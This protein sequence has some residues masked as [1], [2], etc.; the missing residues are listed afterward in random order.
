MKELGRHEGPAMQRSCS[1]HPRPRFLQPQA[2]VQ[3]G[4][5]ERGCP[6]ANGLRDREWESR[7]LSN[8][9]LSISL[10]NTPDDN[11]IGKSLGVT[12]LNP[13]NKRSGM[14]TGENIRSPRE[15]GNEN[16]QRCWKR[17]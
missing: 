3:G 10:Y 15:V 5:M 8:A 12:D 1:T 16:R 6:P 2:S 7:G 14:K 4:E 13:A 9:S 17:G 11:T